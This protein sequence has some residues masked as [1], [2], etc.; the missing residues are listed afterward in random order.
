[1]IPGKHLKI[2]IK[3]IMSSHRLAIETGRW[4]RP[5]VPRDQRAYPVCSA[6]PEDEYHLIL[7]CPLYG[8]IRKALIPKCYYNRP[9][10]YK[11]VLLFNDARKMVIRN[12]AKFIYKAFYFTKDLR[13]IKRPCAIWW[14]KRRWIPHSCLGSVWCL[15]WWN[16]CIGLRML[17]M[18]T[19]MLQNVKHPVSWVRHVGEMVSYV[20]YACT[21]LWPIS[22][23]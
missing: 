6:S 5:V 7:I 19:V 13:I 22:G 12:L 4:A 20:K 16:E 18:Y 21:G 15:L 8:D 1:M 9:S 10:M 17:S 2:M 11:L 23:Q 3:L 14:L